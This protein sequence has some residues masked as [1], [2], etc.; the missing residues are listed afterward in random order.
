VNIAL[1]NL[2]KIVALES[3]TWAA[4]HAPRMRALGVTL[5]VRGHALSATVTGASGQR[6]R[7]SVGE[8]VKRVRLNGS[9]RRVVRLVVDEEGVYRA[10]VRTAGGW[11]V[12]SNR[13]RVR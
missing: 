8:A 5:R 13:V 11:V 10:V 12:R 3:R 6:V 2:T 7:V 1:G 4:A 9:G